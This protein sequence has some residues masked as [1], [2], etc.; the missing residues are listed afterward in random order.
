MGDVL[1]ASLTISCL[2]FVSELAGETGSELNWFDG[3]SRDGSSVNSFDGFSCEST[4]EAGGRPSVGLD[5][6]AAKDSG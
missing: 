1:V 4:V 5:T 3:F 2:L 6:G